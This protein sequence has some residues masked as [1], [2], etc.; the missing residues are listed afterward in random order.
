MEEFFVAIELGSTKI[1]GVAGRKVLDG[2]FSIL[3][4][5]KEDASTCI[6]KG[7]VYNIDK[8]VTCIKNIVSKLET[9]LKHK[10]ARVYV[11]VGGQ[12]LRSIKNVV[13]KDL[14][15]NTIVTVN[16]IDELRDT[17]RNMPYPDME[18]LNAAVQEYKVDNQLQ[19]EPVGI[20]CQHLDGNFLNIVWRKSF[21]SNLIR[22]FELANLKIAELRISLL[23]LANNVLTETEKRSGCVLV[24]LGADTTS[25]AVYH[26]N[27]LRHLAVI[28]LGGN[29]I[30][31]DIAS[32]QIEEDVAERMKLKYGNAMSTGTLTETT[33][34]ISIDG[35][36]SI[37]KLRFNQIVEA[38]VEEIVLNVM[39]QIPY[40]YSNNLLGGIILTGGGANLKNIDEVFRTH[41]TTNKVRIARSINQDLNTTN[42]EIKSQNAMYNTVLSLMV[43]SEI[44]CA[45]EKINGELFFGNDEEEIP[46]VPSITDDPTHVMTPAEKEKADAERKE[47]EGLR[48]LDLDPDE[49][50]EEPQKERKGNPWWQQLSHKFSSMLGGLFE[51]ED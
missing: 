22:C 15:A 26:K 1:I 35:E 9:Q 4:V 25:V 13:G 14:P 20:P 37:D 12:S 2:S 16:M 32:E 30:T 10:I 34:T 36:R 23:A 44:N 11:G 27:I 29:N 48:R 49:G 51:P 45:G 24:D 39:H 41:S 3:A 6:R 50:D 47:R 17:N 33:E 7:V 46:A 19:L 40:E 8:T 42:A 28:P 21:Y 18:I 5:A 31:R 38:R 43:S